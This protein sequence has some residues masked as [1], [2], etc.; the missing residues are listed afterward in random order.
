MSDYEKV[1]ELL[2]EKFGI[3]LG[4]AGNIVG[5]IRIMCIKSRGKI[6]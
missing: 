3:A 2:C 4:E 5:S 1:I 6:E